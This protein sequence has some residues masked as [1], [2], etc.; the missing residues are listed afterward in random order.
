MADSPGVQ[1]NVVQCRDGT[2]ERAY[3]ENR[4][5]P[6]SGEEG[7]DGADFKA[8]VDAAGGTSTTYQRNKQERKR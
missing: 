2:E 7:F 1:R 8:M 5:G 4:G 3:A 6:G